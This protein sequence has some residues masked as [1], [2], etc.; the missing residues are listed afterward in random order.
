M[1]NYL[2]ISYLDDEHS[3]HLDIGIIELAYKYEGIVSEK[4]RDGD[5]RTLEFLFPHLVNASRFSA[6]VRSY[7]PKVSLEKLS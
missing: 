4:M 1:P 5:T 3:S 2:E 6:D 7:M